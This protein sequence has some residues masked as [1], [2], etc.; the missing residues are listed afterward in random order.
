MTTPAEPKAFWSNE[1]TLE[2]KIPYIQG[3]EFQEWLSRGF[4]QKI[5][6]GTPYLLYKMTGL[7]LFAGYKYETDGILRNESA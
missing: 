2:V 5:E 1:I 6:K 7:Q 4:G 3:K